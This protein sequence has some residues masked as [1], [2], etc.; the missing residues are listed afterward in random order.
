MLWIWAI[1]LIMCLK[2]RWLGRSEV[3]NLTV[4]LNE[5]ALWALDARQKAVK[6]VFSFF[7]VAKHNTL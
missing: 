1:H 4:K 7:L 3:A 2:A 5:L 6:F